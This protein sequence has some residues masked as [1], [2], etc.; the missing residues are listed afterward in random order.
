MEQGLHDK[1]DTIVYPFGSF[2]ENVKKQAQQIGFIGAASVYFGQRPSGQDLY[3]WRRTM[4]TNS[5]LGPILLRK[6]YI[7]FELAK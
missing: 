6:L 4:I 7:A 1:I 3:S 5:D 2:N